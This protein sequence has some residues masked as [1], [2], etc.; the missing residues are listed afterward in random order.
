MPRSQSSRT[1]VA[2]HR[3]ATTPI[4]ISASSG[5]TPSSSKRVRFVSEK[6]Q[7][8]FDGASNCLRSVAFVLGIEGDKALGVEPPVGAVDRN[9]QRLVRPHHAVSQEAVDDLEQLQDRLSSEGSGFHGPKHRA[10]LARL[11]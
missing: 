2:S 9:G 7:T 3:R 1:P 8:D 6:V 11:C 10:A 5:K 4:G